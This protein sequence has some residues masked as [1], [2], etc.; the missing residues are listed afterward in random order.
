[1]SFWELLCSARG[2]APVLDLVDRGHSILAATSS[3]NPSLR[4][5][6]F[7]L[8]NLLVQ[9]GLFPTKNL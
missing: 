6:C 1:M 3:L 5:L 2:G 8:V 7:P 4:L 9:Q